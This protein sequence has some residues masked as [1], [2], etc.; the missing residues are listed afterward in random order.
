[1]VVTV[2]QGAVFSAGEDRGPH[3][4]GK[5]I[6]TSKYFP[7]RYCLVFMLCL[8]AATC[9]GQDKRDNWADLSKYAPENAALGAPGPGVKRVVF[10]G[11]SV[12]EF[13]RDLDSAYFIRHHYID[14]GVSGQISSQMLV[15]F[16]ADVVDLKPAAVVILAG[17]NDIAMDTA[18]YM[19]KRIMDNI[20]SMVQLAKQ[21]HI[22]VILC[23]YVPISDYPWRRGI[24][25]APRIMHLNMLIAKLARRER[26]TLLDYFTPLENTQHGQKAALTRDGVHPNIKGYRVL[27]PLTDQMIARVLNG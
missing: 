17:S 18:F 27:E 23:Q 7:M 21:N 6:F 15:R 3:Y 2:I 11:S 8:I 25:P 13:W 24:H 12:I 20:R 19:Y 10:M 5:S 22:K 4:R 26:V 9:Y 14:R 1:M 16:Q